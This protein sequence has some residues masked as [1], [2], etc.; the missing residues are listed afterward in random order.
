M[1]MEFNVACLV[2]ALNYSIL[3]GY[4]ENNVFVATQISSLNFRQYLILEDK[5]QQH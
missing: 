1:K 4:F 3:I 2:L 5:H